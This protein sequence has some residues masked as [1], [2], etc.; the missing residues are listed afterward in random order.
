VRGEAKQ[1]HDVA[2]DVPREFAQAVASKAR[3]ASST[4]LDVK[5]FA[6]VE[7]CQCSIWNAPPY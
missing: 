2:L 3:S 7:P 6:P 1:L 5:D 4:P